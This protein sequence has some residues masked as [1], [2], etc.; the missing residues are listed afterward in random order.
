MKNT[1]IISS[2]F[3]ALLFTNAQA[4]QCHPELPSNGLWKADHFPG[5]KK[6]PSQWN[7][8]PLKN[9]EEIPNFRK[10][11]SLSKTQ[12]FGLGQAS[13]QGIEEIVDNILKN[14]EQD[15]LWVSF[16]EEP[17]LFLDGQPYT[18]RTE[19]SPIHNVSLKGITGKEIE[20]VEECLKENM[21]TQ[22]VANN[23]IE[24]LVENADFSIT[25]KS[26]TFK[27]VQT[28]RSVYEPL[29][30]K[31]QS[32]GKRFQFVRIPITD[33]QAPEVK[34]LEQLYQIINQTAQLSTMVLNCHQ[35]R[36]RT[37]SGIVSSRLIL[38]RGYSPSPV[39]QLKRISNESSELVNIVEEYGKAKEK[40]N[41]AKTA[42]EKDKYQ[43]RAHDFKER[44]EV[45]KNFALTLD[46]F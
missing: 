4:V 37:T 33:E 22:L 5:V 2:I 21:L 16:R 8:V 42:D 19:E 7:N 46:A 13:I 35:G 28:L 32:Q 43:K 44:I 26:V 20:A 25:K 10:S 11:K 41:A 31:A 6:I 29:E 38:E 9:A 15:A 30:Q 12:L 1:I 36:G 39:E 27:E 40:M 18:L 3:T 34:D 24:I 23:S 45:I 17:V 14:N